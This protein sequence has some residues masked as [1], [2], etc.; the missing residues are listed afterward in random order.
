MVWQRALVATCG[1][2]GQTL[3]PGPAENVIRVEISG[4]RNEKGQVLC[5][6]FSSPDAFLTKADKAVARLTSKIAERQAI[7]DFTGVAVG[8]YA[9]SVVHDEKLEWQT[10]PEFHWY[11]P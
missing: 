6:L 10:R 11:A 8:T 2:F 9:V 3:K 5:T 4:L 7:C 1:A